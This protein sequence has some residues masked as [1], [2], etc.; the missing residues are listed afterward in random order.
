MKIE[1]RKEYTTK[2]FLSTF[3]KCVLCGGEC[4]PFNGQGMEEFGELPYQS[5]T[6]KPCGLRVEL[7]E[8][9]NQV[10]AGWIFADWQIIIN[11]KGVSVAKRTA[12]PGISKMIT[13]ETNVDIA[14]IAKIAEKYRVLA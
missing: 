12:L 10:W 7:T 3:K 13:T 2:E 5:L 4:I 11:H 6:C 9:V 14:E 8:Y 1:F